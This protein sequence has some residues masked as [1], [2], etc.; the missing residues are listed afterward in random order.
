MTWLA[1]PLFGRAFYW[2]LDRSVRMRTM[3]GTVSVTSIGMYGG[4]GG[5]GIPFPTAMTISLLV[6]GVSEKPV[7]RDGEVV[8]REMLDLTVT[9]DH[10]LVDGAP[11]ARF[12][13]YLRALLEDPATASDPGPQIREEARASQR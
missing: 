12:V 7:V 10:R 2:L 13:K 5:F 8:V 1:L 9:A 3:S 6:G 4:G 11:V